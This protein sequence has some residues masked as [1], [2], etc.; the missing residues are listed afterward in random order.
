MMS[1]GFSFPLKLAVIYLLFGVS[2]IL[3]T[4]WFAE[5]ISGGN[6]K[7]LKDME[8]Y[9]GIFFIIISALLIFIS[10]LVLFRRNVH[11]REEYRDMLKKHHALSMALKEGIYE[12]DI[13]S[14]KTKL[15]KNFRRMFSFRYPVVNGALEEWKENIAPEDRER[16]LESYRLA[17]EN[18][19]S[20][21]SDEYRVF[22]SDGEQRDL[23]HSVQI[24]RN[25]ENKAYYLVGALQDV[26]EQRQLERN[27]HRQQLELKNEL[28]RTII[29]AEERER[30]RWAEELHDN[31]G[32]LLN[33]V[34]LYLGMMAGKKIYQNEIIE[35]SRE[36]VLQCINEI[37]ELSAHLRPPQFAENGLKAAL[38][39][40]RENIRRVRKIDI[41]I[42]ADEAACENLLSEDQKLMVYRIVQEQLNNIIKYAEAKRA[43]IKIQT[44]TTGCRVIIRDDGKGFDTTKVKSGIGLKNIRSRLELFK[45]SVKIISAPGQGCELQAEFEI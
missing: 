23:I 25:K 9:K 41:L 24:L 31:I 30:K 42:E 18:G 45:G 17:L 6:T 43:E 29:K 28:A 7:T 34:N 1:K 14:R 39:L 40:L 15:S 26:T 37:R 2:W 38:L 21:W 44:W 3:V 4:T 12:Y 16:V 32:Q 36:I 35:K 33:V 11:I 8:Q 27:L 5:S 19:A 13:V 20:S 22:M 10:S